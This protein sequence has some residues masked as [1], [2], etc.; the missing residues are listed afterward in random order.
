MAAKN[1]DFGS[2]VP[3]SDEPITFQL[4]GETFRC[5]P[6]MQG[7]AMV[8][9]MVD[10]SAEEDVG[11]NASAIIDILNYALVASDR[12]RFTAMAESED[13]IIPLDTLTEIMDW[14]VEQYTGR[15]TQ[16]PVS[17]PDGGEITGPMPVAVPSQPPVSA[18]VL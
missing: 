13:R 9:F 12:E 18:S 3:S 11:A 14:L 2:P 17:S 10:A 15:P 4:Y 8:K 6:A 5:V 7:F 1:K 16:Q